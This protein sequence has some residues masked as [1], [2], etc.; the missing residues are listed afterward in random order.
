MKLLDCINFN[1]KWFQIVKSAKEN[2]EK[3]SENRA[4]GTCGDKNNWASLKVEIH[5]ISE[6]DKNSSPIY[7]Q[8]DNA[9]QCGWSQQSKRIF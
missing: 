9:G 2:A 3:N 5:K 1:E 8:R 6:K 7:I 4:K